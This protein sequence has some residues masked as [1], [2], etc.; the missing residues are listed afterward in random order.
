MDFV[1]RPI[2]TVSNSRTEPVDDDWDRI[3]SIIQ[4]DLD[5]VG[6]EAT[7]GLMDFSHVEVIYVFDR[8]EESAIRVATLTGHAS[9]S[10]LS[11]RRCDPTESVRRS[12]S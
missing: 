1:M 10:W 6:K 8:V 3:D 12:A 7:L 9:A 4:L 2:G 11:G 5:V